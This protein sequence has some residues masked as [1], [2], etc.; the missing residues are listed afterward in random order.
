MGTAGDWAISRAI[1]AISRSAGAD[2][3]A[4]L[5]AALMT[6]PHR[7]FR[8]AA[9][10]KPR[11]PVVRVRG[12]AKSRARIGGS[13]PSMR[14]F[15]YR[16]SDHPRAQL[17]RTRRHPRPAGRP[18]GVSAGSRSRKAARSL[19]LPGRR[20]ISLELPGSSNCPGAPLA[21]I[22]HQSLRRERPAPR[23]GQ[24]GRRPAGPRASSGLG[25][26]PDQVRAATCRSC[27]R[28]ATR[29]CFAHARG[30]ALS[31]ST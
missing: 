11:R 14:T 7:T 13:G 30:S 18:H 23:A 8:R 17:G 16:L 21:R 5:I 22:L 20:T 15:V 3:V 12:R 2:S 28:A 1:E 27:P 24:G 31:A 26:W 6:T 19:P 29:S 10:R 4:P 25:M 9:D